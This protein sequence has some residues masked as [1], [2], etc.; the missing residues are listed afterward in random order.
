VNTNSKVFVAH[1]MFVYFILP[2]QFGF[3]IPSLPPRLPLRF[4]KHEIRSL[5]SRRIN[6]ASIVSPDCL[7]LASYCLNWACCVTS[8]WDYIGKSAIAGFHLNSPRV[9]LQIYYR[10]RD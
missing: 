2:L 4:S 6:L 7:Y 9:L 5:S 3:D 10:V 1:R 8:S